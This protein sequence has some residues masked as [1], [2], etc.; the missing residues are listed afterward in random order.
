MNSERSA[1]EIVKA[2]GLARL[3]LDR[4]PLNVVDLAT[5]GALAEAAAELR[6]D[7]GFHAV[8]FETAGADFSAG[9]DVRDHL[10]DR[11]AAMIAEF[12]RACFAIAAIEAPVI[13]A[14][15]GRALGGG[16]ELTLM[17]DVVIA[18]A[19][20][21][22]ALPEITLGVFPPLA[23][24]ALPRMIPHHVASEMLLT[25]R[26]L[27][28][29]EAQRV[30]LVNRVVPDAELRDVAEAAARAFGSFSASSLRVAKHALALSR[31]R[32][33]L[34]EVKAA[35]RLYND[36]VLNDED[37]IEGLRAFME[38]RAPAWSQR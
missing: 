23:A 3:I 7:S 9:V 5:A 16:C 17:C 35:E 22:F 21:D 8:I 36:R 27:G 31:T 18:A 38:K 11:G 28:A 30:G 10:P 29:E 33:T 25:G 34:E 26:S 32:P 20:A 19:S 12:H 6:A 13:C 4:P 1:V 37:A 24:V 2:N 15:Q 14:V